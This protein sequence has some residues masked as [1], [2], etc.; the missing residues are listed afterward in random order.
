MNLIAGRIPAVTPGY[1]V[2]NASSIFL[3]NT[4]GSFVK[5]FS[6]VAGKNNLPDLHA[7][8]LNSF[9]N[10][11]RSFVFSHVNLSGSL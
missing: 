11:Q 2:L 6:V 7:K 1:L 3:D 8:I 10:F 5:N 9:K 4:G